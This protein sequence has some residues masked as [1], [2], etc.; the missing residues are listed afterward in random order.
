[1]NSGML[2]KAEEIFRRAYSNDPD[3]LGLIWYYANLLIGHEVN[4][5][6]GLFSWVFSHRN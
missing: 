6:G 4:V 1:M 2:D 5:E 3:D